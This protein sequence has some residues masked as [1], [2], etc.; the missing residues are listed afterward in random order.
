[1]YTISSGEQAVIFFTSLGAGFILGVLY[2]LFRAIRLAFTQKRAAHIFFDILYCIVAAILGYFYIL[3]VNKG[4]VRLYILIGILIGGA[5][6]YFSCGIAVMKLTDLFVF[7]IRKLLRLIYRVLS[8]PF[9]LIKNI[10]QK[11]LD[12]CGIFSKKISKFNKKIAQKVLPKSRNYVYNLLCI[13]G[14]GKK[15]KRKGGN[16]FGK[17]QEKEKRTEIQ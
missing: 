7:Y 2:D 15:H 14:V 3:A 16:G 8:F 17:G 12:V 9:R 13:L 5:F 11:A 1:M 6:Y 4:E 10:F